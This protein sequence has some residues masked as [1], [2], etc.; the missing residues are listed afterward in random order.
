MAENLLILNNF[1]DHRGKHFHVIKV[2]SPG[3]YYHSKPINKALRT[4]LPELSGFERIET[5]RT[6]FCASYLNYL[7]TNKLIILPAYDVKTGETVSTIF[8]NLYPEREVF[9]IKPGLFYASPNN[10]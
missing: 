5:I 7:I 10:N 6:S 9:K 4:G 3:I 8:Q 1:V 2:P